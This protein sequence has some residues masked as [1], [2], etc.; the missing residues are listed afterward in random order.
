MDLGN[1]K[2]RD[3]GKMTMNGQLNEKE[4]QSDEENKIP[5]TAENKNLGHN[6]KKESLGPNTKR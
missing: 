4:T 6:A 1:V 3:I 2:S 5:I